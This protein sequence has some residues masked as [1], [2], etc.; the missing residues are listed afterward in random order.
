M[1]QQYQPRRSEYITVLLDAVFRHSLTE[2]TIPILKIGEL[3]VKTQQH[4]I[5]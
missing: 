2:T 1:S 3:R 4:A 5:S